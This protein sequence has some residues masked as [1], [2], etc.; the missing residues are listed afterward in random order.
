MKIFIHVGYPKNASTSLETFLFPSIENSYYMGRRYNGKS[1]FIS[2]DAEEVIENIVKQDSIYFDIE[3]SRKILFDDINTNGGNSQKIILSAE[4]FTNN[5][6]DRGV[7]ANRLYSIFP[8]AK[9]LIIIREQINSLLSMY[10]YLVAQKGENINL[11]YGKPSV[12]SFSKWIEDQ[13]NFKYRSYFETLKY[14][15]LIKYYKNLFGNDNVTVLIFEELVENP[16]IFAYRLAAYLEVE[17]NKNFINAL[18]ERANQSLYG[19]RLKYAKFRNTAIYKILG[20]KY[21]PV[22]KI[23]MFLGIGKENKK[24]I[25]REIPE[26]VRNKLIEMYKDDNQKLQSELQIDLSVFNYNITSVR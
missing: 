12:E 22:S 14:Y 15:N 5:V 17:C 18:H 4:A 13:E 20:L 6:I 3:R 16:E 23:A 24:N 11:S 26:K 7:I 1:S 25:S 8:G 19:I 21:I 10:S 2:N 9:I